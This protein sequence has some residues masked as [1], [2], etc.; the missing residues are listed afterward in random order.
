MSA[1]ASEPERVQ[2]L[3]CDRLDMRNHPIWAKQGLGRCPLRKQ[4]GIFVS[5][6]ARRECEK[7][8][9]ADE[10]KVAARRRVLT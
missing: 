6:M 4:A 7:H 10:K 9:A 8:I 2:C 3:T 1:M 5:V